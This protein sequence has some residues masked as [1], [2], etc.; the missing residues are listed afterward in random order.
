MKSYATLFLAS[1]WL[2]GC[3]HTEKT[4]PMR[5]ALDAGNPK[6]A[7]AALNGEARHVTRSHRRQA[8]PDLQ[9]A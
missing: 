6:A 9:F 7:I 4:A 3:S 5:T 2:I 1:A 8:T